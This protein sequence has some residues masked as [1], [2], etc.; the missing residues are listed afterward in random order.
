MTFRKT[1]QQNILPSFVIVATL[2][3]S[4]LVTAIKLSFVLNVSMMSVILL[5]AISINIIVHSTILP[6]CIVC[7]FIL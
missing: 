2:K 7:S 4:V 6:A 5:I 3:S 1:S